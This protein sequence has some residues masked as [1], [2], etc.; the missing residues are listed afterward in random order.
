MDRSSDL[1]RL[2]RSAF[3]PGACI[4]LLAFFGWHALA[5]DT[6]LLAL[7]GYKA[8]QA[9]LI[10]QAEEVAQR[11]A[12][13]QHKVALLGERA[14]PDYAEELVRRRLGLVRED[15]IIVRLED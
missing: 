14:E 8:E 9:R 1:A 2:F 12:E 15:E 5:G 7:G 11:R 4:A 13:L 10:A 3:A 6:G